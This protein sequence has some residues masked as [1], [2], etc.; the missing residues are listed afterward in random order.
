MELKDAKKLIKKIGVKSWIESGT[1]VVKVG[2]KLIDPTELA[3]SYED[4]RDLITSDD[5]CSRCNYQSHCQGQ[6]CQ[7]NKQ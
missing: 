4:D 3:H 6:C 5:E 1:N 2:D 7:Y